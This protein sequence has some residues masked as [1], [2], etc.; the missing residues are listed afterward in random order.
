MLF[1]V[2]DRL[3]GIYL[4]EARSIVRELVYSLI[5]GLA[6]CGCRTPANDPS[7]PEFSRSESSKSKRTRSL[8]EAPELVLRFLRP[9]NLRLLDTPE[10]V[11]ANSIWG[12]T[13]RDETG[14]MYFGV[15]AYG[16]DDPS[17]R[18]WRY[19]PI[20]DRFDDMGAVN[21]KLREM[22]I[23]RVDRFRETQMKIHS[24]IVEAGDGRIYFS[25][26]DEHDEADDGS[27]NAL[28]GGRLFSMDPKTGIW[29]C[30]ATTPEGLIAVAGGNR[31]VC[32]L[33]YFGHV[34]Y[35]YDTRGGK[36]KSIR[37][38][39]VGGH[40]S[41]NFFMDEREHVFAIRLKETDK[42]LGDGI[43]EVSGKYVI[44]TL[45]EF[46]TDLRE[47]NESPLD[48]YYPS[49]NTESHGITG[50]V[51]LLDGTIVF[52][53]HQGSLWI[54]KKGIGNAPRELERMGWM[55]PLGRGVCESLFSP[56]GYR[57][58][59]GFVMRGKGYQWVVHDLQ[60][61]RSVVLQLDR[62]SQSV[63]EIPGLGIYGCDTLDNQHRAYVAGW[64]KIPR[65][66]GPCIIQ[67]SW[68]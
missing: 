44:A 9:P 14:N 12:A 39:T 48:D 1:V 41:R 38:G 65:G 37:V 55:H 60:L 29:D 51:K 6:I 49:L 21:F 32:A 54:L 68:E 33:G 15:A 13:G 62:E 61:K 34:L 4:R 5:F 67:L 64:K 50:Y 2:A 30:V 66:N 58:V 23:A 10:F 19:K 28:F 56:I 24:K 59:A 53:T 17:A 16:V 52:V 8:R 35:Q 57:Y 27:R 36:I 45:V 3:S 43:S 47:V 7:L 40:V 22:G 63:L 46:D 18:L 20:E 26:Q 42:K 11:G 31:Y 25:S